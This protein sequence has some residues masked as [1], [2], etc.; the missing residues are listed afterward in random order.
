MT[1]GMCGYRNQTGETA[2]RSCGA[3]LETPP[4]PEETERMLAEL[5][6]RAD[7]LRPTKMDRALAWACLAFAPIAFAVCFARTGAAS[8]GLVAALAALAGAFCARFPAALWAVYKG[9]MELYADAGDAA[10]TDLWSITRKIGY[11][12]LA[13]LALTAVAAAFILGNG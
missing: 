11:W 9:R 6:G 12:A 3:R 8:F 1:C 7:L 5:S 10:P 2:C 13:G 4:A